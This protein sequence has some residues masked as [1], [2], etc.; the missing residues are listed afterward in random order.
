MLLSVVVLVALGVAAG[1]GA[2][3]LLS[4]NYESHRASGFSLLVTPLQVP[5]SLP[6]S[7]D[8]RSFV[9]LH[10]KNHFLTAVLQRP[11]LEIPG[12]QEHMVNVDYAM[13]E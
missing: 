7:S 5:L 11:D 4:S 9:P 2:T 3:P 13:I 1:M 6:R 12:L 8:P 10:E